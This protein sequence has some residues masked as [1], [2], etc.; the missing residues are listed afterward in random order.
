MRRE[1]VDDV[2]VLLV[3]TVDDLT[4]D[5]FILGADVIG[6]AVLGDR[7][8]M[9]LLVLE[10]LGAVCGC[11]DL[12]DL[13]LQDGG[14]LLAKQLHGFRVLQSQAGVLE[15]QVLE[16]VLLTNSLDLLLVTLV[17]ALEDVVEGLVQHVQ[18]FVVMVLE[19]HLHIE[20]DELGQMTMSEGLLRTEH[21]ADFEDAVH[22][23]HQRHLLVELRGL[24]K[25]GTAAEIVELEDVSAT[26]RS[27]GNHLGSVDF[28]EAVLSQ[29]LT[30]E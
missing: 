17:Q 24:G 28:G 18:H 13:L 26:L 11:L 10:R 16:G 4:E 27:S 5:L 12:R 1:F 22:V 23:A 6:I 3:L 20:A 2:E 30:E 14:T 21:R 9:S 19:A 7:L 15:E 25:E 29:D 8:E